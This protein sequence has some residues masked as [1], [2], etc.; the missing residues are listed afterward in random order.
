MRTFASRTASGISSVRSNTKFARRSSGDSLQGSGRKRAPAGLS[1]GEIERA[2]SAASARSF[3]PESS[4]RGSS[5]L[6]GDDFGADL[7]MAL[8]VVMAVDVT[9]KGTVGCAYYVARDEKLYFM[10]DVK[11]GGPDVVEARV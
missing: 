7:D 4:I 10:E 1:P 5:Q 6:P 11:P 3:V 8:E 9:E 2:A